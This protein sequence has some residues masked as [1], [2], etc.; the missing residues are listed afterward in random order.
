[1]ANEYGEL[2]QMVNDVT[3]LDTARM[4]LRWALERLNTIEKDKADLKKNLAIAEE[5]AKKLQLKDSSLQEAYTS[6]TKT[7]EEKEDF[8]TKLEA[9]MS[10]LGEGKLDIQQL[11]K[12]EAKLDSLRKSLE[13]EYQSKFEDLD[14]N[15]RSVIE[16]WNGRL[17]EVESQYAG[18][19]AEAQKKYD[20]LRTELESDYQGRM[21]SLQNTFKT[22]EKD[23]SGR[24]EALE[25]NVRLSEEK[26]EARRRELEAE[27][28]GKK[29]DL[30]DNYRKVKAA[31][32]AG[33]DEKLRAMD[34][35]HAAQVRS[36]EASWQV[37]RARMLDEQRIREEQFSSAQARIKE[38]ENKL[39]AQQEAHHTELIKI[40]SEKETAFRSQI[41]ALE[42]EKGLK[43]AA[44]K[45][46][47]LK[48]E[49]KSSGWAQERA[50]LEAEFGRKL[51]DKVREL[52]EAREQH[53]AEMMARLQ[54]SEADFRRK[55][56][57]F[58]EEKKSYN[59][60]ISR[61]SAS[62]DEAV[63]AAALEKENFR[64]ELAKISALGEAQ[65]E[66]R[67]AAVRADYEARKA[68]LEKDFS[69]RYGDR[70]KAVEA[71]KARLNE[72]LAER[73]KQMEGAF[74]EARRLDAALAE[75]RMKAA[76]EKSGLSRDY[77][78][79]MNTALKAAEDAAKAR[80]AELRADTEVLRGEIAERDRLLSQEKAKL[81]DELSKAALAAHNR[82]EGRASAIKA[83]YEAKLDA[84]ESSS[85]EKIVDLQRSLSEKEA[86]VENISSE[87]FIAE[88]A[89]KSEFERKRADLEA[90]LSKR[91]AA[92]EADYAAYKTRLAAELTAKTEIVRAEVEAKAEG[93]RRNWNSERSRLERSLSETSEHFRSAQKDIEELN[94]SL[95]KSEETN[96]IREAE[97]SREMMEAKSNFDKE[98]AYR[99]K[100]AV[101]I[102]TAHLVEAMESSKAKQEELHK[103][104]EAKDEAIRMLKS[105]T[106]EARRIYEN[107]I[108]D[109]SSGALK[110]RRE[111]LERHYAA[112]SAALEEEM[113]SFRRIM[114]SENESLRAAMEQAR[115]E[116]LSANKRADDTFN[117]MLKATKAVQEEKL[118]INRL[119]TDEFNAAVTDAV[120]KAVESTAQKLRHTEAELVRIQEVNRDEVNLLTE[121]FNKEKDRML[122][123]IVRR[124]NYLESADL[125]IQE[126]EHQMA[127]LRQDSSV[128]LMKHV[129]EH[130]KRFR[131][132]ISGEKARYEARVKQLEDLLAAKERLL[133]DGENIYRQKQLELD[134]MHAKLN[135][136]IGRF[137]EE[138]FSQKQA[139][140]GKEKELNDF[141]LK[142][143]K[144]YAA[145]AS[146]L[147]KMRTE[148]AHAIMEY[149]GRK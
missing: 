134:A 17:L 7:L 133:A 95:R 121:S 40:I 57:S 109:A 137:N 16:R 10:L 107:K 31:L 111:E 60:T 72:A 141:R 79:E 15:Q 124:E 77:E 22:R 69:A 118:E 65:A 59:E 148:L 110:E 83:E 104:I 61:L 116:V 14:R 139:L 19:L 135:E 6:R 56:E 113:A 25:G 146:D 94:K 27:F 120:R 51:S 32:E 43:E 126:L 63:R 58:E 82:A 74:A 128:D 136:S 132:I 28:A 100:D 101:S 53:R 48:L 103:I 119:R 129:S 42:K 1:M 46:L 12:K 131:D 143:E 122:E 108:L 102:Q 9:T 68:D 81:V 76:E 105:E 85:S 33:L 117:D 5:A 47:V 41:A 112:K 70:L 23:L 44:V 62:V 140:G 73:E 30:E 2:E 38:I 4:T 8:Y 147:E 66:E 127:S 96:T 49:A 86:L 125:K 54:E 35:D 138:L 67:N 97:L 34:S 114:E 87:R 55:L 64:S 92:L 123:E 50:A 106:E 144:D 21:T 115:E 11:L 88:A 145:K 18:R 90:E 142:L 24:I 99:V 26:V 98:L 89:I 3:S 93:E 80:E 45:E 84:L 39:A 130:D 29:R 149:K 71:E 20:S 13:D 52:S 78:L 75:L 37:E 91:A 36:L